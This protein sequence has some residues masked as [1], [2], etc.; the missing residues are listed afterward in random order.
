[1]DYGNKFLAY[2]ASEGISISDTK[3]VEIAAK[4]W[5]AALSAASTHFYEEEG[6]DHYVQDALAADQ[7]KVD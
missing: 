5:D 4:A 7:S 1:M 3:L 6:T 2:L